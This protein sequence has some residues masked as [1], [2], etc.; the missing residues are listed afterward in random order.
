MTLE[1]G[2]PMKAISSTA[3]A[4]ILLSALTWS[5]VHSKSESSTPASIDGTY[6]LTER[7][8][9]GGTVLRSPSIAG[10]YT[11]A[12]GHFNL[13]IFVKKDDG[14]IASESWTIGRRSDRYTPLRQP[15]SARSGR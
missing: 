2:K 5:A 4:L 10:L 14:T 8:M 6:E 9:A 7:V 12:A 1:M 3:C 13:N 11:Q 15:L